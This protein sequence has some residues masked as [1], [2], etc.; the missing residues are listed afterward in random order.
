MAVVHPQVP[1]ANAM[2]ELTGKWEDTK[3]LL[4]KI[5]QNLP[6]EEKLLKR[7]PFRYLHDIILAVNQET[8]F[9]DGLYNGDE[10]NPLTLKEKKGVERW[11]WKMMILLKAITTVNHFYNTSLEVHPRKIIAGAEGH[12]TNKF[13]QAVAHAA[14]SGINSDMYVQRTLSGVAG[15]AISYRLLDVGQKEW[16]KKHTILRVAPANAM[17]ELTGKWED[18]KELLGKIIQN[19]P[20][21][22]KLLKRPPFR[23]LHDI[24]LAVNQETNF[25]DG[26]YNGDEMNPLTLK[27][28]KGVERWRWKMMILLKAITTVNHFYNTSL[29]VHPR[30]IIAGAEGHLTNKFLQAVAHAALSGINSDMYVQRT[31]SGVAGMA[32]SYRMLEKQPVGEEGT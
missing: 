23:Y 30:K 21:E 5:I 15:T 18:T 20:L 3:E 12:L 28:K 31:L 17:P 2:P 29:E 10:M 14:L 11:R 24:I 16:P 9:F 8:N 13:L 27:E 19:L 7:P 1:P 6:L 22:E 4:G 25:F 26:L 32:I